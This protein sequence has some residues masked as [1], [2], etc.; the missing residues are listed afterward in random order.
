MKYLNIQAGPFE[1][2]V[3]LETESAPRT[4]E[5]F[6]RQLP[7]ENQLVHVRWSGEAVWLPLDT[8][9]FGV[10]NENAT[11]FPALGQILLYPG[12]ISETEIL[13]AYGAV[14]FASKSASWPEITFDDR[15]RPGSPRWTR[16]AGT[17]E[18]SSEHSL[19][20]RITQAARATA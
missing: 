15:L 9:E 12:G 1:F 5:A 19:R 20:R 4:C 3:R 18:R 2:R 17:L 16:Q 10:G 7:F 8:H 13:I 6:L 14:R 11:S